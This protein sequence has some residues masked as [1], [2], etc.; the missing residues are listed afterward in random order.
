[1]LGLLRSQPQGCSIMRILLPTALG[2]ALLIACLQTASAFNCNTARTPTER[3]I[4]AHNHL[5]VL[6]AEMESCYFN[7]LASLSGSEKKSFR[8]NQRAW[9]RQRNSCGAS[10][11]CLTRIYEDHVF[12]LCNTD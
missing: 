5:Q 3:T 7:I 8:N 12:D 2:A 6:D 4:C 1:M 10:V 11:G 9:L